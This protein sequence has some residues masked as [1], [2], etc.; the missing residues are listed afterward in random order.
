VAAALAWCLATGP[1]RAD[2]RV[3]QTA[4]LV[5]EGWRFK[6]WSLCPPEKVKADEELPEGPKAKAI[7]LTA[8]RGE[9]EPLIL[10]VRSTVPMRDVA[11]VFTDL[12]SEAGG[13][14]PAS[15][16]AVSR[17]AYV[18]VDFPSGRNIP[19]PLPFETG[20]GWYPD[21]VTDDTSGSARPDWNLCFW[22]KV[23]VPRDAE[24][25][26]YRGQ[27]EIRH[28][29][30]SWRPEGEQPVRVPVSLRVYGFELPSPSPLRNTTFFTPHALPEEWIQPDFVRDL[31]GMFARD[32]RSAAD[33]V[34]PSPQITPREDGTVEVD[35]ADWE[36]MAAY[37]LDELGMPHLFLPVWAL[38]QPG[39]PARLQGMYFIWHFP[40]A[41]KQRWFGP[42]IATEDAH[43][44][45]GFRKAFGSYLEQMRAIVTRHGWQGRIYC[46]TMD[47][48]YTYH[49][50]DR[51]RDVRDNNYR[52]AREFAELVRATAPEVKTFVTG[53]PVP[54]LVGALDHW[55]LRRFNAPDLTRQ[56]AAA[57]DVVTLCD[58]YRTF[59]DY[60]LVSPRT[61]AWLAWKTGAAGWFTYE[62]LAGFATAWEGPLTVYN[63]FGG[64]AVWGLGHMFYPDPLRKKLLRS[65]RWE[66]M[67]EGCDDYE[68]LWL[69]S[70]ELGELDAAAQ[71]TA[72]ARRARELIGAAEALEGA[73]ALAEGADQ[74]GEKP[75][76]RPVQSNLAVWRVRCEMAETLEALRALK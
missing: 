24:A 13:V 63:Q 76:A 58:N 34:L 33:P 12:T 60:P 39:R 53:D 19:D 74:A 64:Q 14:V 56:R 42:F 45:E 61:L 69:L 41:A 29:D 16:I 28:H 18:H 2:T 44:T 57:G 65:L 43:L 23:R 37:C 7:S 59:V 50:G 66:M 30:E 20:T 32:L 35:A 5:G 46:S 73:T 22:V 62:T 48:P 26:T 9:A 15:A 21:V 70:R 25:G 6:V 54:E 8:A 47:E 38:Y 71:A 31:Y 49:T 4:L 72:T 40:N 27:V 36:Q 3:E 55:C 51:E 10:A 75:R 67:A 68:Y 52:L 17:L 11:P 1:G